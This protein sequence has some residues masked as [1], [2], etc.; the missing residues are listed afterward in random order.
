MCI[1]LLLARIRLWSSS[2][3]PSMMLAI[4]MSTLAR[5]RIHGLHRH[6]SQLSRISDK[7]GRSRTTPRLGRTRPRAS[8]PHAHWLCQARTTLIRL[9]LHVL[10]RAIKQ[11]TSIYL[12]ITAHLLHSAPNQAKSCFNIFS[13][14]SSTFIYLHDVSSSY[15]LHVY[16][17]NDFHSCIPS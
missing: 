9:W 12:D 14:Y 13:K 17:P 5:T 7:H 11:I 2:P 16:S 6:P 3:Y 8:P 10:I 1:H 15:F 4:C